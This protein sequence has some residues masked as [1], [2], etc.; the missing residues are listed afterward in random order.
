MSG[1]REAQNNAAIP[2]LLFLRSLIERITKEK[3]YST[4]LVLNLNTLYIALWAKVVNHF[5]LIFLI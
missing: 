3:F 2:I 4:I 1:E 5:S